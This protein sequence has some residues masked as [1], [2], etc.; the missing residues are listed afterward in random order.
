MDIARLIA[1]RDPAEIVTCP[2]GAAVR[3]AVQLLADKRIGALPVISSGQ[4]V[5]IIT[6]T[7]VLREFAKT[8]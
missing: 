5:G 7:D 8:A 2:A 4:L 3:E 1:G 6:E